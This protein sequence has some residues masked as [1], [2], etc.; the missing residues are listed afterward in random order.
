MKEKYKTSDVKLKHMKQREA[1]G[2]LITILWIPMVYLLKDTNW[3]LPL[4]SF[5]FTV[6]LALLVLK[7]FQVRYKLFFTGVIISYLISIILWIGREYNHIKTL[8][9]HDLDD[10]LSL[11][12][13]TSLVLAFYVFLFFIGWVIYALK[14]EEK[15]QNFKS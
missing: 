10:A 4:L 1:T 15:S 6:I 2:I 3:F 13:G 12:F 14:F 11:L 8:I 7:E 5:P 9:S